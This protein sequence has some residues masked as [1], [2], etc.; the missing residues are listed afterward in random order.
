[1]VFQEHQPSH[2]AYD[3]EYT[4]DY[5]G[6][7]E[8]NL[9]MI[10][11]PRTYAPLI[12]E[13][14]YGRMMLDVGFNTPD[15][16][17]FFENRGW[18]TWGIDLNENTTYGG[19]LYKG[20]FEDYDFSVKLGKRAKQMVGN[21]RIERQFDLIWMNHV[22]EHFKN[23]MKALKKAY[24]LLPESGLLYIATPDIDF[25]MKLS[26]AG[27]PH[28]KK[29]EHYIMWSERALKRELERV[30]FKVIV[31]RRNFASRFI[32]WYDIQILAE[33]PYF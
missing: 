29:R 16:M 27:F 5:I 18:I 12:E 1:M 9:R 28:W 8:Y 14:T 26:S 6:A 23:P 4:V 2:T 10:H 3:K 17:K 22:F 7:K 25:I 33:K 24:D 30:G 11:A 19:N 13:L 32:S 15:V 31:S 21:E 20:S